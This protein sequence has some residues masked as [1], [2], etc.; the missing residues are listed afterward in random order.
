M[1]AVHFGAGNIG[2]GFIGVLLHRSGFRVIFVDV[3]DTIVDALR[4]RGRYPVALAGEGAPVEWVDNVTA[5][6]GADTD[7]VADAV[8]S[9]DLVTTAIGVKA[10]PHIAPALAEGI[11]RR[12]EAGEAGGAP[13]HVIACENTIGG[14]SQL[15]DHVFRLLDEA[16]VQ[17]ATGRIAFPDSAVDRIVPQQQHDDPLKVT[18]EP[19][20]EWV[21]DRGA[22]LDGFPAIEGAQSVPSLEPYLLRKLFTVNTGHASA[23]YFGY[24]KG[25]ATIQQVMG[26]AGLRAK[27]L[28][29]MAETGRVLCRMFGFA[30]TEHQAYI[31][32]IAR[33]FANPGLTDSVLRVGR[34]PLRKLSPEDRFI[35][36]AMLASELGIPTPCLVEAIAAGLKFDPPDDE[37]AVALQRQIRTDGI[38]R[39]VTDVT[40]VAPTHPLHGAIV[41]QVDKNGGDPS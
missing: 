15:R 36:P 13:L 11:R 12:L 14:S 23:A 9:A 37:E 20:F 29:V 3:N 4:D 30:E 18:V 31:E 8:A 25:H 19:Y 28:D 27:V 5:I 1:I 39:V 35:R 16:D 10:L 33:R 38:E 2:R 34:S 24:L 6:H 26:D 22:M 41:E 7:A 17:Q 32:T 40:G 21:L